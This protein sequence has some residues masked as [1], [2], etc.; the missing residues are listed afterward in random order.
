MLPTDAAS[1]GQSVGKAGIGLGRP[2]SGPVSP[3]L[4]TGA[5]ERPGPGI[6]AR[7]R[8]GPSLNADSASSF[9]SAATAPGATTERRPYSR[10]LGR[11]A[12]ITLALLWVYAAYR[13][14][15]L[16]HSY[17]DYS[18]GWFVP[19]LCAGLFWERWKRRPAADPMAACT[20]PLMV[21]GGLLLILGAACLVFEVIPNWRFAGWL[22]T[23]TILGLSFCILLMLGGRAWVNHFAFPLLFFLI[24]VPWPSAI[25]YPLISKLSHLNAVVSTVLSNILGTPAIRRGVII[26][27]GAGLVGVDDACSGIRS[28]QSTLMIALFLGELFGYGFFRRLFFLLSGGVLAFGCNVIRTTYLVRICDLKGK[29]AVNEY[30]DQAGFTI[31][32]IT[33]VGLLV[34]AWMIRPKRE[35]RELGGPKAA[36]ITA[37]PP[38]SRPMEEVER[39]RAEESRR[40]E[41][42]KEGRASA[43]EDDE[44]ERRREARPPG[45]YAEIDVGRTGGGDYRNRGGD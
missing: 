4:Q 10:W 5:T 13:M 37:K 14:G 20:G 33:L 15:T 2:A 11:S 35:R 27:T 30:H 38:E 40:E 39:Q 44:E 25:E 1:F 36:A 16:W 23:G 43:E 32:G 34:W 3:R 26:E 24:A 9:A 28:F 42:A 31:M 41:E 22:F 6:R 17:K 19:L 7:R 21:F 18:Y 29:D 8:K 12:L 45:Q